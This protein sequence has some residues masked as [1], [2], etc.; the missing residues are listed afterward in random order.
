MW[1][2]DVFRVSLLGTTINEKG[3]KNAKEKKKE[4]NFLYAVSSHD[5]AAS[6]NNVLPISVCILGQS[7][8]VLFEAVLELHRCLDERKCQLCY[9]DTDSYILAVSDTNL[10]N[11]VKKGQEERWQKLRPK[12]FEDQHSK[13]EQSG[14]LKLEATF[15]NAM[16]RSSKAYYLFNNDVECVN[17]LRSI[18]SKMI[19][20]L[21]KENTFGQNPLLNA[22]TV[23]SL[24]MKPTQGAQV[25][26]MNQ[27]RAISHS[28]NLKRRVTVSV[29]KNS[30][31]VKLLSIYS[32]INIF[33]PLFFRIPYI[34]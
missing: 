8:L 12:L 22:P 16:F 7:K 20:F 19:P 14:L 2:P 29:K 21:D 9:I 11:L 3:K 28:L 31:Y 6:I 25:V 33:S 34:A 10:D 24:S 26:M 5:K 27:T 15:D 18:Q 32:Y 4:A 1:G 13:K 17:R 23:R 30:T